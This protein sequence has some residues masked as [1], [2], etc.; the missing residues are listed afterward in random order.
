MVLTDITALKRLELQIRQRSPRQS[1]HAFPP[2]WR[3]RSNPAGLDQDLRATAAR[4]ISGFRFSGN[5][6][7]PD[8]ARDR[9]DRFAGQ[10]V[11]PLRAAGQTSSQADARARGLGKVAPA[12]RSSIV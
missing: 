4:A 3:T 6:L 2:G 5:I 11:A 10:P 12:H 8:R 1:G 9:S 7:K